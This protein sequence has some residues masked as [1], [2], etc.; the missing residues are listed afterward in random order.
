MQ[1]QPDELWG[2]KDAEDPR[3]R[4]SWVDD[5]H[6]V[7]LQVVGFPG[8]CDDGRI[9]GRILP[10]YALEGIGVSPLKS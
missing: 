1:A 3:L 6:D 9:V 4:G 5:T 10:Q 7:P 8:D 2:D